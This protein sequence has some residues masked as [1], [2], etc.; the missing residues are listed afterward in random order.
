MYYAYVFD[1]DKDVVPEIAPKCA[2]GEFKVIKRLAPPSNIPHLFFI[3][4]RHLGFIDT[5]LSTVKVEK[6]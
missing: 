5:P 6:R 1:L 2:E 4:S 3:F